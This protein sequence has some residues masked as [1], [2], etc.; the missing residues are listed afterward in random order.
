MVT[1]YFP[2]WQGAGN[3][4]V[5]HGA[6]AMQTL[7]THQQ[8]IQP[9]ISLSEDLVKKNGIIGYDTILQ[10]LSAAR[11]L[12]A[13]QSC[14]KM[15]TIGGGCDAEILP[16]SYLNQKY[17]GDLAI[18]WFDAHGDLNTPESS[19]SGLFHGMPLRCLLNE[20]DEQLGNQCFSYLQHHQVVFA[21]GRDFDAPELIYMAENIIPCIATE[22]L[23]DSHAL[24]HT[25]AKK[26]YRRIYVHIDLDVLDPMEFPSVMCPTPGGISVQK[27]I[28]TLYALH[29]G[30]DVVGIGIV[31]YVPGHGGCDHTLQS[32]I[33]CC[34]DILAK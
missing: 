5:Y 31:E 27:L 25:L 2:A 12:L 24:C 34:E 22:E 14:T 3:K 23:T 8:V 21:C 10:Q 1:F 9:E 16:V 6:A 26:A 13:A 4:A 20:G 15:L 11:L 17:G 18:V 32:I 19:P 28:D 7:L 29:D 33:A 30:F